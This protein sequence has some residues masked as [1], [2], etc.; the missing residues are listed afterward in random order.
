MIFY[1]HG[2]NSSPASIKAR[3]LEARMAELDV[4]DQY[5]CPALPHAPREAIASIEVLLP[6]DPSGVT[7]VGSSLGGYYATALAERH[8]ARAVLVNPAVRPW[9]LLA[10]RLGPQRNLHTGAAWT[11]TAGHLAEL[12]SLAVEPITRPERYL[13]MVETGDEVLDW[14][15]AAQFYAGARQVVVEGGDHGFASFTDHL[16]D[17]LRFAGLLA[18][19]RP[20]RRAPARRA[21]GGEPA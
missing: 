13:L 7:F 21:G 12:E 6:D 9:R 2:F 16:D 17:I 4:L 3:L 11:L 14:R 19:P 8:G 5:A 20:A 1:L 10:A 18:P 15:D